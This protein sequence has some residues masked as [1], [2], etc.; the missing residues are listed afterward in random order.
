MSDEPVIKFSVDEDGVGTLLINRPKVFNAFNQEV[1]DLWAQVLND[2]A[3]DDAVKVIVLTGAGK[4]FCAG[5]DL[6]FIEEALDND[7]LQNKNFLF[8]HVHN[9]ARALERMDKPIIAA[10]NGAAFG[11]GMDMALMCD[12]RFAAQSATFAESYIAVGLTPGDGG[13]YYLPRMIGTAKALELFWSGKTLTADEAK[14][15]GIVN[16][17]CPDDQLLE[18]TYAFARNVASKHQLAIR[19]C[20]RMVYNGLGASLATNLDMI[21]SQMAIIQT[22][23][24][25]RDCV[26]E[27]LD[28]IK[29]RKS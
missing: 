15:Y 7:P 11:A 18:K 3:S 27:L 21:S 12:M 28:K 26:I 29:K 13:T 24:G 25:H 2:A 17:V 9:V 10:V 22:Q 5:G 16:D 14:D 19:A 6:D 4:A 23:P 20:K 8:E 1:V